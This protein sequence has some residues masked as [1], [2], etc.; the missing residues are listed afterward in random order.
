MLPLKQYKTWIQ[1]EVESLV[2][3]IYCSGISKMLLLGKEK[4]YRKE[5]VILIPY[6]NHHGRG[7]ISGTF[8]SRRQKLVICKHTILLTLGRP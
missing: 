5:K 3:D 1:R 4:S 2:V 7:L 8:L 6:W